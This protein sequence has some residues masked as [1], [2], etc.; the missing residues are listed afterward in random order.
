MYKQAPT[1]TK[2]LTFSPNWMQQCDGKGIKARKIH[3]PGLILNLSELGRR[4]EMNLIGCSAHGLCR[5]VEEI[6]WNIAIDIPHIRSVSK[7][8]TIDEAHMNNSHTLQP[9]RLHCIQL[10]P[11]KKTQK[12]IT[13][14]KAYSPSHHSGTDTDQNMQMGFEIENC[15]ARRPESS[16]WP[17]CNRWRQSKTLQGK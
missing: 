6:N 16:W 8:E 12:A 9:R 2:Y 3:K 13:D 7:A 5:S 4:L 11:L 14:S 17:A 10:H 1:T 15:G